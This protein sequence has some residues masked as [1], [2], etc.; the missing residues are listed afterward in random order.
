MRRWIV[1]ALFIVC[2][3]G[4][5]MGMG[6]LARP[7]E[8]Y[9][10]LAKPAFAPPNWV[11]GPV[12][13]VMYVLIAIAGWR[14]FERNKFG[15]SMKLWVGQMLVNLT[16]PVFFFGFQDPYRAFI[17]IILTTALV[18]WYTIENWSRD[19][20]AAYLFTPYTLWL[21]YATALNAAVWLMNRAAETKPLFGD[22][23][24][25]FGG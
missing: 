4:A 25:L 18:L 6:F 23:P 24:P 9:E 16:W 13:S 11:F 3:L 12:W 15:K 10:S 17:L 20:I 5:G 22:Q 7:T 8:W 21:F 14:T 19:R 2:V 1:L